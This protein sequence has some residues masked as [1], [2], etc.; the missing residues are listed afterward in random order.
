MAST[1]FQFSAKL[2]WRIGLALSHL[3][4][5]G[6][7]TFGSNDGMFEGIRLSS[8]VGGTEGA[9]LGTDEGSCEGEPVGL[10]EGNSDGR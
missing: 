10:G 1:V 9:E 2:S 8:L 4:L 3:S 5:M 6:R 7:R